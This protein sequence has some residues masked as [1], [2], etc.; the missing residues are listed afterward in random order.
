MPKRIPFEEFKKIYSRV[1]RLTVEVIV[2]TPKGIVL[3]KRGIQPY[4]NQ[5]HIPGGTVYK[6]ERLEDAVR[7]VAKSEMGIVVKPI[8]FLGYIDYIETEGKKGGFGRAVGLVFLVKKISG[9]FMGSSEGEEWRIF[10][11]LPKN[12]IGVQKEFLK[13]NGFKT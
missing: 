12:T 3:I 6:K 10:S 13:R 5:W 4:K 1:P 9:D 2:K 7:R 11:K 8:K